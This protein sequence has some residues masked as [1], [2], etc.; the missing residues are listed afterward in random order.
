MVHTMGDF[1]VAINFMLDELG[2]G[3]EVFRANVA[4]IEPLVGKGSENLIKQAL[5]LV[6]NAQTAINYA[7]KFDTALA[8]YQ[9][10]YRAING[11]YD[12]KKSHAPVLAICGQVPSQEMGSDFFQEVDND[13][14]FADVAVFARTVTS[15][16]QM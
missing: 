4:N 3:H 11:L 13:R 7:A 6:N 9:R 15:A 14:L 12:A 2:V 16:S 8:S 1:V 5:A 10:H